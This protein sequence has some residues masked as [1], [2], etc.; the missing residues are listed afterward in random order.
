MMERREKH[1]RGRREEVSTKEGPGGREKL[2]RSSSRGPIAAVWMCPVS[3]APTFIC[4]GLHPL[5][6]RDG[7]QILIREV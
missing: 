6:G 4:W 1:L 2:D 3:P 7:W 5:Q